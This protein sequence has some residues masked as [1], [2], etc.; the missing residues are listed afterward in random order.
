MDELNYETALRHIASKVI[1][2]GGFLTPRP[3]AAFTLEDYAAIDYLCEEWDY[4]W[5]PQ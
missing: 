3:G 1:N 5:D 2:R 4:A